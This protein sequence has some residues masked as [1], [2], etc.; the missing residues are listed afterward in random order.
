MLA[1]CPLRSLSKIV[2]LQANCRLLLV[3][4]FGSQNGA[5]WESEASSK[6][7]IMMGRSMDRS[8]GIM[9]Q[10]FWTIKFSIKKLLKK[11]FWMANWK[12]TRE[13]ERGEV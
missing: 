2:G 12:M 10:R 11:V 4:H 9:L 3:G 5:L 6:I 7:Y 1:Y 13:E 8:G